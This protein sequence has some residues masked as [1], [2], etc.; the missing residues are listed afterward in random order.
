MRCSL[1]TGVQ[2]CALPIC[3]NETVEKGDVVREAIR[4]IRFVGLAESDQVRR[5]AICN[6]GNEGHD[7]A[8]DVRGR[9]VS[10]Q[11]QHDWL[12]KLSHDAIRTEARRVGT[13]CVGTFGARWAR[14]NKKKKKN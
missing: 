8:P 5:N 9:G 12:G 13:E 11:E 14:S 6:L 7:V 10:M 3:A 2:T 4:D 1:V